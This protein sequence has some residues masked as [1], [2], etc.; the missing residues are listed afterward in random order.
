[1]GIAEEEFDVIVTW[2][3]RRRGGRRGGRRGVGREQIRVASEIKG[4]NGIIEINSN[5][6]FPLKK[7]H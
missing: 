4:G 3:G 6:I 1:M 7:F 5:T 2:G